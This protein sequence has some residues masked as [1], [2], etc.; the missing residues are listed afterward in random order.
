MSS[1]LTEDQIAQFREV[2]AMF[3]QDGDGSITT[4]ELGEVM[5]SETI[6]LQSEWDNDP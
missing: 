4:Q 6:P 3:D 2:F 5:R 1:K